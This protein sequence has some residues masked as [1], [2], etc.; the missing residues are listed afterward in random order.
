MPA[1]R[2]GEHNV[3]EH[4]SE[5]RRCFGRAP[6]RHVH[7]LG[8][9]VHATAGWIDPGF[10]GQ[11]VLEL[12]NLSD[13]PI[14]L[15]QGQPVAQLVFHQLTRPAQRPYGHPELGSHYQNQKGTVHSYLETAP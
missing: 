13:K 7:G 11:I 3:V 9:L 2:A 15:R 10:S 14:T 5:G 8:L 1:R 6:E 12:K 4:A